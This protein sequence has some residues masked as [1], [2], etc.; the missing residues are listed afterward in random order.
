MFLRIDKKVLIT[1]VIILTL[2]LVGGFVF[3]QYSVNSGSKTEILQEEKASLDSTET[4][5]QKESPK[6]SDQVQMQRI[7]TQE[8]NTGGALVVCSDKCGDGICQGL[9]VSCQEGNLNCICQ[10]DL[11][12]CPQDCK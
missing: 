7:Q 4:L 1:V 9:D 11:Q 6:T 10:E 3:Y 12:E 8:T 5:N 2:V